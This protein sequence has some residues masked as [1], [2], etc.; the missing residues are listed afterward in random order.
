ML[1]DVV[2]DTADPALY[3]TPKAFDGVGVNVAHNV[4]LCAVIDAPMRVFVPMKTEIIIDHMVV[5]EDHAFGQDVLFDDAHYRISLGV[6]RG[7]GANPTLALYDSD[8]RS[9]VVLAALA[10]PVLVLP[11]TADVHFIN[12]DAGAALAAERVFVVVQHGS[13]LLK[14]APR[15]LIRHAS[16]AL[17]LFRGNSTPR[18]CHEIDRVE[19]SRQGSR[20]FVKDGVGG[21]MNMVTAMIAR[22]G[23]TTGDTVMLRDL[24][25]VLAVDAIGV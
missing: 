22:V 14:H 16:F 8:H 3:E 1:A 18:L 24:F 10:A 11:F 15:R 21:W 9:F 2:V 6:Q 13:N 25:A 7:I 19:P 20:R 12:F 17:N 23:R 5:S 4:D